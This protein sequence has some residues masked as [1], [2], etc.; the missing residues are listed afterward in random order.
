MTPTARPSA[1]EPDSTDALNVGSL[2]EL[3]HR[4]PGARGTKVVLGDGNEWLVPHLAFVPLK[5]VRVKTETGS[6]AWGAAFPDEIKADLD[7]VADLYLNGRVGEEVAEHDWSR[8]F[9]LMFH[10]L[11]VNYPTL[12]AEDVERLGLIGTAQVSDFLAALAGIKKKSGYL[13]G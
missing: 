10:V 4:A 3:R 9:S 11:R 6:D 1:F 12:T 8:I 2:D 5:A 13:D 7:H